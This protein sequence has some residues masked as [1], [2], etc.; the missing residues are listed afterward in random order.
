M[1]E[2]DET[3]AS[4][5]ANSAAG[6]TKNLGDFT[7]YAVRPLSTIARE[8]N[9]DWW[10]KVYYGA[11]P[12]LEAMAHLD[13]ITDRYGVE[14]GEIIVRYFLANAQSWRGTKAREIK[15]ELNAMLKA[16]R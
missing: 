2:F 14:D 11:K 12:Y 1:P 6:N 8:I 15:A 3:L 16:S 5:L 13:K 4:S 7:Q 9:V 10:G